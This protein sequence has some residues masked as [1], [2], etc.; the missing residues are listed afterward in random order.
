M[1]KVKRKIVDLDGLLVPLEDQRMEKLHVISR[2]L[3]MN[4][5]IEVRAVGE[6]LRRAIV[7]LEQE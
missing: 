2:R 3:R 6:F 1:S 4:E 5:E 7:L